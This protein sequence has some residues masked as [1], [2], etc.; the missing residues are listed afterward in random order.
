ML[1]KK[2]SFPEQTKTPRIILI[3][4]KNLYFNTTLQIKLLPYIP[5]VATKQNI[6]APYI[7]VLW[8]L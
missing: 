4:S 1:N 6:K 3:D 2:N 5:N 8:T 7:I